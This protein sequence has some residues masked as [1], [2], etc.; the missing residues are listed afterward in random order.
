VAVLGHFAHQ[1][2]VGATEAMSHDK[3]GVMDRFIE[4]NRLMLFLDAACKIAQTRGDR[5]HRASRIRN[6]VRILAGLITKLLQRGRFVLR[7]LL[8]NLSHHD[9]CGQGVIQVMDDPCRE[10]ANRCQA[11]RMEQMVLHLFQL[12]HIARDSKGPKEIF[13]FITDRKGAQF[14]RDACA[15]LRQK[16]T[17]NTLLSGV[18]LH[19]FKAFL[20]SLQNLLRIELPNVHGHQLITRIPQ[21]A[22]GH[23]IDVDDLPVRIN[24]MNHVGEIFN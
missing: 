15:V 21:Q 19:L 14:N 23:F 16:L 5:P 12:A 9:D 24:G 13:L 6:D 22:R 4:V 3:K 1:V 10:F 18:Q 8:H 11:A 17:F 20:D 2:D 7:A